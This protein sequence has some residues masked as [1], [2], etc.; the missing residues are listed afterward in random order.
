MPFLINPPGNRF[1]FLFNSALFFF[2]DLSNII[3]KFTGLPWLCARLYKNYECPCLVDEKFKNQS[4]N[5]RSIMSEWQ[6]IE[7]EVVRLDINIIIEK[8]VWEEEETKKKKKGK[9]V[10]DVMRWIFFQVS[11]PEFQN[12]NDFA[13]VVQPFLVDTE[14]PTV[15]TDNGLETDMRYLSHDCFHP[16][17]LGHAKGW[18]SHFWFN[19]RPTE[20]STFF[21]LPVIFS[22]CQCSLE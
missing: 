1:L 14:F 9:Y 22:S 4:S 13:A 16:S 15:I 21:F 17:Q 7:T 20:N 12:Q 18:W 19:L 5:F 2:S 3:P 10:S 6:E 11:S 8:E